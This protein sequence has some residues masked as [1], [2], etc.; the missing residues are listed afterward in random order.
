MPNLIRYLLWFSAISCGLL[1]GVYFAFSAFIMTAFG[2][3]PPGHG[4]SAMNAIN[5]TILQSLFMP[6]FHGT[7]F[8]SLVLVTVSVFRRSEPGANAMLVGGV[9]YIA[10]MFLCTIFFNV[11]LNKALAAVDPASAS[12]ASVWENY[13][14]NW[15][16]WNHVRTIASTVAFALYMM[17]IAK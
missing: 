10:G 15:T 16:L 5:S 7:T 1:A 17:A 11:P 8:L 9:I 6:F 13:L 12:A 4:V 2:R 3:I 14:R